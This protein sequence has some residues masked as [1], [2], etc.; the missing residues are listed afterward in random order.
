MNWLLTCCFRFRDWALSVPLRVKIMGIVLGVILLFSLAVTLQ[1][2]ATLKATLREELE[3]RGHSVARDVAGRAIDPMITDN[4]FAIDQL[5][6]DR[7]QHDRDV[8]YVFILDRSG[9]LYAH[10][11][12]RGLP[13][14]L[15]EANYSEP[16]EDGV[17][18]VVLTEEG[19]VYD[20]AVPIL[21][22]RVGTVRVGMS[23]KNLQRILRDTTLI[24]LLATGCVSFLGIA[25]AFLLTSVI[26]RPIFD[27]VQVTEAVARGDLR[28]KATV[29]AEDEF[30]RLGIAFNSMTEALARSRSEIEQSNRQLLQRN[31]ELSV[32][33]SVA[34]TVSRSL[35][36]GQILDGAL[37]RV[38]DGV[39]IKAGWVFL[40]EEGDEHL[41]LAASRG[42]S[43][44]FLKE[45]AEKDLGDCICRE[46]MVSG[47]ARIVDDMLTCP[48]LTH[49][50]LQKEGLQCH[51]SIPLK[52]KNKVLGIMNLACPKEQ[53]ITVDDL[54]LLTAIGHQVGI[55]IENARLYEEVRQKE[56]LRRR[57]L[58]ELI[59]VQE[60]ERKRVARE[61]HD[62]VG[63][64]LT[65]LIMAVGSAEEILPPEAA[66]VRKHL[67]EIRTMM[68][69][70]VEETRRLMLDLRPALLDDLGLIPAIRSYAEAHLSPVGVQLQVEVGGTK[71]KLPSSVDI[72]LFRVV[73][74]AVT[75]IVKHA[76]ASK[77]SIRL[78]F[79]KSSVSATIVDDGH[80]FDRKESALE[81]RT[82]GLLGMEE[83]TALLGGTL[84]IDSQPNGGTRVDL[85]IPT[86]AE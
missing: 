45:E 28:Q 13:V 20:V 15:L 58:D 70:V 2:R 19:L 66:H 56:A 53:R 74:E 25:A 82:F 86:P 61:L 12:D 16:G 85:Q 80:G 35:D 33:N 11:F 52:A 27:L 46:V 51:A 65:A 59:R 37:E 6:R 49:Q 7:R 79:N 5:I 18:K 81:A 21:E 47:E 36:L 73:Q 44:S 8:R 68:A 39:K 62:R 41:K 3:E 84:C 40:G 78:H 50:V 29:R 72:A 54:K 64:N 60:E 77:A 34:T 42:L 9:N 57:L 30:G 14:G 10:T 23:E 22:G 1:V 43:E 67:A 63:Q 26:T 83:R 32:L 17:A 71:R 48:R 24:L 69:A 76:E 31:E 4:L 55:A 75:N 38:L